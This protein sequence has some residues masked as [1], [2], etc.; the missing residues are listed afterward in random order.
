[1][2]MIKEQILMTTWTRVPA[3]APV[4]R[5]QRKRLLMRTSRTG[6]LVRVQMPLAIEQSSAVHGYS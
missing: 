1:M 6:A 4:T 5:T 3:K 2:Q